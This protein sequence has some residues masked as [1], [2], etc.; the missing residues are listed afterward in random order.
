MPACG[1]FPGEAE[2]HSDVLRLEKIAL[3]LGEFSLGPV[4]MHVQSG[5][6]R[7][8][9]GPTG[10]GK[11]VLLE[12]VA[13]IRKPDAGAVMV[14]GRDITRLAP[15]ERKF[16]I[17]YQDYA[18][19]PHMSVRDNIAFGLRMQGRDA[20]EIQARVEEMA[21]FMGLTTVLS[22]APR[23]LSG[24]E[25]QRT[26]LARA[27]VLR[28]RVL[29]LDEPL[30]ALDRLTRERLKGELKRIHQS[31]G[32]TILHITHDLSEAFMLADTISVMGNGRV[33][34]QGTPDDVL[35]RP[36]NRLVAE[37]VGIAGFIRAEADDKGMVHI[38][39]MG[40]VSADFFEPS[41]CGTC[42]HILLTVPSWAVGLNG[43]ARIP[44]DKI[45]WQGPAT[46][47]SIDATG[48]LI[49]M[50]LVFPGDNVVRASFSPREIRELEKIPEPGTVLECFISAEGVHWVPESVSC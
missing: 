35:A 30:S 39:G 38:P 9:L 19:F 45:L 11:T 4:D 15:E 17:V 41:P 44:A 33:L 42:R 36:S 49:S 40:S 10:T 18:L 25:K 43:Q 48:T 26:A 37:L 2:G 31:L 47:R 16:G 22:R 29:L 7:V 12:I 21:E 46:I 24:G 20:R 23:Y 27:L 6:Y 34:Q 50:E 14:E 28:P 13:G 8:V 32:L 1:G 5:E 3:R